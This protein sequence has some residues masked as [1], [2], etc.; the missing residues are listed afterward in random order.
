MYVAMARKL[1]VVLS[2]VIGLISLIL[3]LF[4]A[5]E[6]GNTIISMTHKTPDCRYIMKML[7]AMELDSSVR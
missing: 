7:S 3:A 5:S 1:F 6:I 2:N 4:Q